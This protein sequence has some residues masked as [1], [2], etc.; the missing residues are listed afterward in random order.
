MK[1]LG[2]VVFYIRDLDSSVRFYTEV[3]G[4]KLEGLIFNN[5]AAVLT[6]GCTHHELLLIQVGTQ[7]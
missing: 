6:G 3:V 5:R 1:E 2:H 7:K 4:L